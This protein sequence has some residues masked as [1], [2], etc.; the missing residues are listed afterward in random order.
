MGGKQ[1][2]AA[3]RPIFVPVRSCGSSLMKVRRV[4]VLA[5]VLSG[6]RVSVWDKGA[7]LLLYLADGGGLAQE[8]GQMLVPDTHWCWEP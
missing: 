3:S 7:S 2:V 8:G 6:G 5:Y 4:H 1:A